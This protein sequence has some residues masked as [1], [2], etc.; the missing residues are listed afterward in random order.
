MKKYLIEQNISSTNTIP[1]KEF[2]IKM[3]G[4]PND[5]QMSAIMSLVKEYDD[6]AELCGV[7][8]INPKRAALVSE[9]AGKEVP[10][11]DDFD[12]MLEV[13][14]NNANYGK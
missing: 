1:T 7:Y 10:V 12:K 5:K 14:R 11:Y 4:R 8:D 6:C 2:F 13:Q 9:Y 3:Q